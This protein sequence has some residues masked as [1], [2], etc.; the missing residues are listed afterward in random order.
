MKGSRIGFVVCLSAAALLSA[1]T[2]NANNA[3]GEPGASLKQYTSGG[4]VLGFDSGGYHVSNGTYALRVRFEN[5]Q[6]VA[7]ASDDT[8]QAETAPGTKA[9]ALGRVTYAGL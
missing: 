4:H 9:P 1:G 6:V 5:A 2:T 8:A 3:P 7:P